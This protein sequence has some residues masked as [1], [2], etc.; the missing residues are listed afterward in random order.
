M[1]ASLTKL[2]DATILTLASQ[3]CCP[4]WSNDKQIMGGAG[5]SMQL[6][7]RELAAMRLLLAWMLRS[8][9]RLGL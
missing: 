3:L 7:G 6:A 1:D 5:K 8:R 2:R 9:K 4:I